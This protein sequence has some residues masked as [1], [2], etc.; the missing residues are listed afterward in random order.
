[1]VNSDLLL[2]GSTTGSV[3]GDLLGTGSSGGSGSLGCSR[4]LGKHGV[5][6]A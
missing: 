5:R 1:M 3:G 2:V 4:G 6:R